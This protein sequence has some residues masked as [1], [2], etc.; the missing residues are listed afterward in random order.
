M[1]KL[2]EPAQPYPTASTIQVADEAVPP[3]NIASDTEDRETNSPGCLSERS[4]PADHERGEHK[5]PPDTKKITGFL[6]FYDTVQ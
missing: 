6:Y 5:T 3:Q 2:L 1:E 4:P